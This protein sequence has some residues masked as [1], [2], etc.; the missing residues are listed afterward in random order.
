MIKN[1]TLV[2]I[3]IITS[4]ACT[5]SNAQVMEC[6][7]LGDLKL[8][9]G[10]YH[11]SLN[12]KRPVC[13]TAPGIFKIRIK[14]V[15]NSGVVVQ[16]GDATVEQKDCGDV[17]IAGNN[18]EQA[19]K[20][21]VVVNGSALENY[22]C[23]FLINVKNVGTLDPR[24]RVVDNDLLFSLQGDALYDLLDTLEI[25]LEDANKLI[26]PPREAE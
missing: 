13:V 6:P 7:P 25:S 8:T 10:K 11:L 1:I 23:E 26:P 17:T 19:N 9:V 15:P 14:T 24:V 18:A 22:E 4:C 2:T 5:I 12:E 3:A 16:K 21:T 20:I